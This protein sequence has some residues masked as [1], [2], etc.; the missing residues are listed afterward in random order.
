MSVVFFGSSML[1]IV[2]VLAQSGYRGDVAVV[3][4]IHKVTELNIPISS[5]ELVGG[6]GKLARVRG[7][8]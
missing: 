5:E 7:I 3:A 6:I 2:H 1:K 8:I 4:H